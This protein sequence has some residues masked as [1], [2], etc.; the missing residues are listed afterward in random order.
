MSYHQR[1]SNRL[2]GY[3]YCST[4]IYFVTV[5]AKGFDNVFGYIE[6]EKVLLNKIGLI[7]YDEW[8]KTSRIRTN[9]AIDTFIIMPDHIHGIIEILPAVGATG[10]VAQNF[11]NNRLKKLNIQF[12]NERD[13]PVS[14]KK[15][16][17]NTK[18]SLQSN[19]LGSI[20]GQY[21]SM[22][23]KKIR[24]TGFLEFNWQRNYYDRIL[25]SKSELYVVRKY[26]LDNPK[27]Y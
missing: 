18:N 17:L 10:S 8:I 25:R 24:K 7:A 19:S 11:N 16:D 4:G 2:K 22:V 9:V 13:D 3:N 1:R 23:A 26:I 27:N 12:F 20:I 21:K 15:F 5:R 14:Y 6:N